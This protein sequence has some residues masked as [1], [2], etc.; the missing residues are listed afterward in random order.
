M[1]IF[2]RESD[3]PS[4]NTERSRTAVSNLPNLESDALSRSIR[5]SDLVA[6]RRIPPG[7]GWRRWIYRMSFTRINLGESP[8][9][10]HY[11]QL[12]ERIRRHVRKQY[13]IGVISG[14]G[15]VGKTTMAACIGV[16][17]SECRSDNIV[18]VDA[19]PGFGTL[20]GRIDECPPG[21]Y[22][23]VLEDTDVQGYSDI[24][25]HLGKNG[26]GLDLLAGNR[27]SDQPRPLIPSMFTGVLARLR[28]THSVIV[29]DTSDDLEHPV[30]QAVL[31]SC[32]T[33]LLVSGLTPDTSL[34]VTR[35]IELLRS[36]GYHDLLSRSVVVL[37]D[38]HGHYEKPARSYLTD[39]FG[40]S[41]AR[42]EF[43]PYDRNLARGGI[44]DSCVDLTNASRLRLFEITA[45][46]MDAHISDA[47]RVQP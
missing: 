13:V 31:D 17:F 42:V 18:A 14:K 12:R 29:V 39:R 1:T 41:G 35:A 25:E 28:R 2:W 27:F 47:E 24:R 22:A 30:M 37:N 10:Q 43:M 34:P 9:E 40:R 21:D 23:A 45:S 6:P 20:A 33:L 5:I 38:S 7:T 44:I 15:G 4:M 19:V 46:L 32:D 26:I 36:M 11:R 8:S 16:V 3:L